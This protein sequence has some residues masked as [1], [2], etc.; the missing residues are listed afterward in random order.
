MRFGIPRGL[1]LLTAIVALKGHQLPGDSWRPEGT[2]GL[3]EEES[4]RTFEKACT[5]VFACQGWGLT[6]SGV[7]IV[8]DS[9]SRG[10]EPDAG[11]CLGAQRC[12]RAGTAPAARPPSETKAGTTKLILAEYERVTALERARLEFM[13]KALQTYVTLASIVVAAVLV[14]AEKGDEMGVSTSV[15]DALLVGLFAFGIITLYRTVNS[16]VALLELAKRLRAL[17]R[18]FHESDAL[19]ENFLNGLIKMILR[20]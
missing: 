16:N 18:Y 13:E 3:T 12:S 19:R 7:G 8:A 20:G 17:R 2:M 14:I 15:A 10:R 1:P 11:G 5:E 6:P 9:G 4:E